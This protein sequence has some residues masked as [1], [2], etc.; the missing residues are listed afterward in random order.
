MKDSV[1]EIKLK[2]TVDT[3]EYVR[4]M[5]EATEVGRKFIE[6]I[7]ELGGLR[8]DVCVDL[9]QIEEDEAVIK[10]NARIET[11]R[12]FERMYKGDGNS[13]NPSSDMAPPNPRPK[14]KPRPKLG[15]KKCLV[16]GK[17]FVGN[18]NRQIC[19]SEACKKKRNSQ[20]KK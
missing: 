9:P 10:E 5:Q 20:K 11:E 6:L 8:V 2:L 17:E 1:N 3:D 16:C 19:C 14:P 13:D 15:K 4:K 18:S 12:K 7:K